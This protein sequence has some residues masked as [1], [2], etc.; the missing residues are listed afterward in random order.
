VARTFARHLGE[1]KA[2]DL[3]QMTLDEEGEADKKLTGIAE[4]SI[5]TQAENAKKAAPKKP[6]K[7][8]VAD[9]ESAILPNK[10]GGFAPNYTVM[11]ATDGQSGLIVD[12][13]VIGGGTVEGETVIPTVER[14]EESFGA[15]PQQFLAD[16]AFATGPNLSGLQSRG[17]EPVMPVEAARL[18]AQNPAPR[19]DPTQPVAEA[20]WPKLPRNPQT[21]QLDKAAFVY[22]AGRNCY[23]CPMGRRLQ[24]TKMMREG[25][26]GGEIIYQLYTCPD[27]SGCPLGS[28]C[29]SKR[30]QSR[31]VARDQYESTRE[32]LAARMKTSAGKEAYA[33]RAWIAETPNA[34]IKQWMGF[35]QFL[36]RGLDKV[37]IEWR[38]A[39]TASNLRKMVGLVAGLRAKLAIAAACH[40]FAKTPSHCVVTE[41]NDASA[42]M[43]AATRASRELGYTRMWSIHPSQIRTIVAAFRPEAD[44]I[45]EA[46]TILVAAQ[47]ADW[48][49]IGHAG[50]LHDRA[51]YRY[52]WR[53]LLRARDA[54]A[55]LPA[56]ATERFFAGPAGASASAPSALA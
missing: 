26:R 50:I 17:I 38:W 3:L 43:A 28:A 55:P 56:A 24:P 31:T 1:N 25:R 11:A 32:E 44:E 41:F 23:Y 51:S 53:L 39:C 36:L 37:R 27:C 12:C 18:D 45:D 10:E 13:D 47:A 22:D 34:V 33:R 49:P 54:G 2:A 14:I 5:N 21:K 52:F 9:P 30:A 48:A 8:P 20:D 4:G 6:A 29:L 7:V 16:S 19:P 35:R 46:V 42:I 15:V 40:G